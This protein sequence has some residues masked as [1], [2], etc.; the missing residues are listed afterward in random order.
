MVASKLRVAIV[1]LIGTT[2]LLNPVGHA[3]KLDPSGLAD[4]SQTGLGDFDVGHFVPH[5]DRSIIGYRELMSTGLGSLFF[6]L[7]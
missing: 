3:F 1:R 2:R 4:G 5:F 7:S 6:S